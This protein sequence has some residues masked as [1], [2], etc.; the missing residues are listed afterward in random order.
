MSVLNKRYR[1]LDRVSDFGFQFIDRGRGYDIVCTDHPSLRGRD[2]SPRKTH[3]H[4]DNRV[5]FV[6][7]QEPRTLSEALRRAREWAE[8]FTRYVR[9]GEGEG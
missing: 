7:G 1:A 9:T 2:P 4:N 6:E 3:L 8:Y 5:C